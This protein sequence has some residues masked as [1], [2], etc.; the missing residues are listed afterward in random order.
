MQDIIF[1]L[2]MVTL[3]KDKSPGIMHLT[4]II[5]HQYQNATQL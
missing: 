5:L 4:G 2:D 1:S 3:N